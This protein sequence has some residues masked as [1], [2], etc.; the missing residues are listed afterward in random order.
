M[1][2]I[3]FEVDNQNSKFN[4]ILTGKSI[5]LQNIAFRAACRMSPKIEELEGGHAGLS[6]SGSVS[7]QRQNRPKRSRTCDSLSEMLRTRGR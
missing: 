4:A 6:A 7:A 2:R 1:T 5:K 3:S